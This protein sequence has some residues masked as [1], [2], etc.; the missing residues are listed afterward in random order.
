MEKYRKLKKVILLLITILVAYNYIISVNQEI[1]KIDRKKYKKIIEGF[2]F[3]EY[4]DGIDNADVIIPEKNVSTKTSKTGRFIIEFFSGGAMH[5]E[6]FK[7]GFLPAST[8]YFKMAKKISIKLPDIILFK[9]PIEEIVVTGTSTPKLYN[10]APVKT[11]VT[12]RKAIEKKGAVSLA[13]LLEMVTGLR[14]ENNCQNCNFTQVRIN[15]MEGKYS[16]ILINGQPVISALAGVYALEQIPS[17]MIERLEVVKG[18]GSALY[19]G[20]AMAGVINVL[21]KEPIK[22]ESRFSFTQEF[23]K[24]KPN[25][26]VNF[27]NEY[28]SKNMTTKIS[29][30]TNFQRREQMDYNDDGFSDL[31]ELTNISFGSNFSHFFSKIDGKLKL[32]FVSIFEDRRGG[33]KFDQPEH[34]ADIAESIKTYRVDFGLGWEQILYSKSILKFD[35]SYSY[36]KRKSYY[37]AEQDPNAYGQT[38]NPVFFC[39]LNYS[40]FSLKNH[41]IVI[42]LNFRSDKIDDIAPA[43]N[44]EINEIYTDFGFY[45][46]DEI[47]FM[48]DITLLVG[49]RADKHSEIENLILSPR[50][51]LLYKGVKNF[52]IRGTYS[53]GFRAPQVFDEDLHITQVGGEGQIIVNKHDLKEEKSRGFTFGIDFGKQKKNKLYQFSISGFYNCL[54]D[55][56]TLRKIDPIESAQVFERFNSKGAKVYGIEIEAGFKIAGKFEIFSGWTFQKSEYDEPEPDFNSKKLFRSPDIYGNLRIE[57]DIQKFVDVLA[58]F[59]Y[60]GSM[61]VPH[62]AGYVKEDILEES[63]PFVVI[64]LSLNRK[65]G[66]IKGQDIIIHAS[67]LNILDNYQKDLDRGAYRDAGYTYGPRVPRTFRIGIRYLF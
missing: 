9:S 16:Q 66:L 32:N 21:L 64:N 19:G 49:A 38:K 12:S 63:D 4:G 67:V 13:D 8:D 31:G 14:V 59:I 25:S 55:V 34:F 54:Y 35:T 27:N 3:D 61:K 57:W 44:R 7:I 39:N 2:V 50:A 24:D 20:N 1:V 42:G 65:F 52:A 28:V 5:I 6:V 10:E 11:F 23:I 60:T 48:D 43:Y 56:F 45:I 26:I 29:S 62:F 18:G 17:N 15:G 47:E 37:G 33:N 30:F 22:S 40:N 46:Q 36:T 41:F 51:S 58:E 53:T